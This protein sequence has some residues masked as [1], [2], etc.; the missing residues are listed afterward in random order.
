[1]KK[2]TSFLRKKGKSE[3]VADSEAS[4]SAGTGVRPSRPTSG[5]DVVVSSS[6]HPSA[7][8]SNDVDVSG[9][10]LPVEPLVADSTPN[11]Y[12][13]V[14]SDDSSPANP[15]FSDRGKME[16]I[17][18]TGAQLLRTTLGI[19]KD[20]SDMVPPLKVAAGAL[21]SV[22]EVIEVRALIGLLHSFCLTPACSRRPRIWRITR[23][24]IGSSKQS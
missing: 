10:V 15:A 7:A 8:D 18:D 13:L 9:S 14:I 17:A 16:R 2:F 4:S 21:L 22:M 12:T 11:P 6:L 1:M 19:V 3:D 20:S 5:V 23:T 24:L